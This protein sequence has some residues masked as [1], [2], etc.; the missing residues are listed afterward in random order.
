MVNLW[1]YRM[2]Q[3]I[4]MLNKKTGIQKT[5][6]NRE[7]VDKLNEIIMYLN[8]EEANKKRK[9]DYIGRFPFGKEL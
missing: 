9:Y 3:K 6:S 8:D 4:G 2:I 5:P 1:E 7:I